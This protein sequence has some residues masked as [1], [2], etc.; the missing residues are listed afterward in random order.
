VIR[1][2]RPRSPVHAARR[3]AALLL[4]LGAL[5]LAARPPEGDPPTAVPGTTPVVVAAA[6]LAP[7]TVLTRRSLRTAGLPADAVPAGSAASADEL[8]G[9]V[10]AGGLRRG[11]PVTDARLVGPGLTSLLGPGQVAAPLRL[12]DLA[13]AGL[14]RAGDRVDVLATA[15]G[16]PTADV[17]ASGALVLAPSS[18][19]GS[20][21]DGTDATAGLLL[22]AVDG[23]TGA[24]LAAAAA[25]DALSVTL[26][27][28]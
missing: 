19:G 20:G 9:Q 3:G 25:A 18:T 1:L 5:V 8:T 27:P 26:V 13:V 15:P 6:D 24:R 7:G 4:A 11:E 28:P 17:V 21:A 16:S 23:A 14:V 22:L 2:R 10:L 12:D